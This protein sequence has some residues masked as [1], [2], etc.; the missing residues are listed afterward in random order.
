MA[1][2][3]FPTKTSDIIKRCSKSPERAAEIVELFNIDCEVKPAG[4]KM[5]KRRAPVSKNE[6]AIN[7][8]LNVLDLNI[9]EDWN[10]SLEKYIQYL[11]KDLNG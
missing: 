5:F 3:F 2:T 8:K 7:F 6:S 4:E 1:Y 11:K 9:M 10:I